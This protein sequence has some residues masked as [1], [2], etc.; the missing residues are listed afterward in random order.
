MP[1][2]LDDAI[3]LL[4][5]IPVVLIVVGYAMVVKMGRSTSRMERL[6]DPGKTREF[7]QAWAEAEGYDEW[8]RGQGLERIGF[9]RAIVTT[10]GF[11]AAWGLPGTGRFFCMYCQQGRYVTEFMSTF[12]NGLDL[13][14]TNNRESFTM[15]RP[16]GS[17]LQSFSVDSID[18]LWERHLDTEA[19]VMDEA[20]V[21][22]VPLK[23]S[24]E[25][26]FLGEVRRQAAYV[27]T[28]PLWPVKMW[29][30]YFRRGRRH[31]TTLQEQHMSG[32]IDIP[33]RTEPAR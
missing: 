22:L 30:W 13:T 10:P 27:R 16:P 6:K 31:G 7:S 33:P 4:A 19:Y 15:P 29:Y 14:T 23:G 8:T 5:A 12:S 1:A 32:L 20:R 11:V 17:Y 2:W 9:F 3:F 25:S 26:F 21:R 28:I 18:E 24:F